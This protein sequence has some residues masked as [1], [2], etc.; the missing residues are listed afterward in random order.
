MNQVKESE[1]IGKE[2]KSQGAIAAYRKKIAEGNAPVAVYVKL[3]KALEEK[4]KLAQAIKVYEQAL[5]KKPDKP[6]LYVKIAKI[7][8]QQNKLEQAKEKYAA[9]LEINPELA[10]AISGLANINNNKNQVEGVKKKPKKRGGEKQEKNRENQEI[11]QLKE[12]L[13]KDQKKA[14]E[15][16]E[17]AIA[18]NPE[19]SQIIIKERPRPLLFNEPRMALFWSNKSGCTFA[20]K[21][22]FYQIGIL[23]K[24]LKYHNFVHQ[25]RLKIFYEEVEDAQ[26]IEEILEGKEIPI[27]KVVR[28]P[29][30]RAASCY[31]HALKTGYDNPRISKFLGRQITKKDTFSFREFISYLETINLRTR[32]PHNRVQ[33]HMSEELG[34]VKPNYV[35]KLENSFEDLR[36]VEIELGLL[37]SDLESLAKSPHH[38][39]KEETNEFCGDKRFIRKANTSFP[40]TINFYDDELQE[41]VAKL[42]RVDFEAYG[43]DIDKLP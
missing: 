4:G 6:N 29:Y 1:A 40:N 16:Y 31:I 18:K 23:E 9:A 39:K 15:F 8:H 21:W 11:K 27:I 10:S 17:E 20:T 38:A 25:Y 37:E 19:L 42:Y 12:L 43:Y 22:F 7:Y 30:T 36:Q 5:D 35:V 41:R 34:L 33:V 14:R 2:G 13:S 28:N 3:G 32:N 26:L 24:A